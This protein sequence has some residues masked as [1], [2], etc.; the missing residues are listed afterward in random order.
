MTRV[1]NFTA[2]PA[3]LPLP[4]LEQARDELLDFEGTG[5]SI[6]ENSHRS[7]TYERVHEEALA[8]LRELMAVPSSHQILF[9]QGGARGQFAMVPLNFLSSG[10]SADYLLTG[11][12]S[13]GAFEEAKILG[14]ARAAGSTK[15]VGYARV[16]RQE[17][18]ELDPNAAYVHMT[19][20]NT[21]YGTQ[22]RR[23]PDV[24]SVPLV[25]DASSDILSRA[26]DVSKYALIYAGAQKNI[27]P[28]GVVVV[29]AREDFLSS[30]RKDIPQVWRYATHAKAGSL[31]HTPPT[32]AIYLM[33]GVLRWV[34]SVGGLAQIERWNDEKAELLYSTIDADPEYWRCPVERESRSKMNV[35]W[36]LPSE[37]LDEKFVKEATA[38]GLV[39]LK[40]YRTVGG[41]RASIYNAVS[42]ADVRRLCD[43]MK[44]FAASN[45]P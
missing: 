33:R 42:V 12:W 14:S 1:A 10:K 15:G 5:M 22:W 11:V 2:G 7:K 34:K 37:A 31:W 26:I 43:F 4:V 28:S 41:I 24:G 27:G 8:L 16:L 45:R 32:F 38:A 44:A 20:N 23:E 25:A 3:A 13:E 40:G 19:T 17:E 6:M 29:I 39:G 21:I 35:V 36:R 18:L 30:A 9:L